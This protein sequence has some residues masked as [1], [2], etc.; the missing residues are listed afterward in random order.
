[1]LYSFLVFYMWRNRK[2]IWAHPAGRL[3]V[4][5]LMSYI[6][7]FGLAVGNFG[8][9]IRHR[10][11]FAVLFIALVAPFLPR[12]RLHRKSSISRY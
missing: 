6:F 1:L 7:V 11:K 12:I 2:T 3:L 8:T 4:L 9:G 5:I 10:A